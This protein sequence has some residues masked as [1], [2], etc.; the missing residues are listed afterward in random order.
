M[1]LYLYKVICSQGLEIVV[2]PNSVY[3]R[4]YLTVLS[5]FDN[6]GKYATQMGDDLIIFTKWKKTFSTSCLLP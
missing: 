3:I 1:R 2:N 6:S 4:E 5:D